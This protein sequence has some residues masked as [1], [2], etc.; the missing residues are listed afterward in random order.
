MLIVYVF[1]F[2]TN[3]LKNIYTEMSTTKYSY[4]MDND[5]EILPNPTMKNIIVSAFISQIN[6]RHDRDLSKY[7]EYGRKLIHVPLPKLVFVEKE[8]LDTYSLLDKKGEYTIH[9]VSL[10][11]VV[12]SPE[13]ACLDVAEIQY[14]VDTT[15]QTVVV[16][17]DKSW[18]YLYKYKDEI[19]DFHLNTSNPTKDTLEYMFVQ[20][21][22][23]E[24]M[25]LAVLLLSLSPEIGGAIRDCLGA[26]GR[27]AH[28][29]IWMDFGLY[30][31]FDRPGAGEEMFYRCFREMDTRVCERYS[32]A[33][34]NGF[35]FRTVYFASC[36][37]PAADYYMDVYRQIHW[38]FAG[39]VFAGFAEPLLE[40]AQKMRAECMAL[41]REKKHLMW[42]I[43]V[44][45][46]IYRK[47]PHLFDFY[48]C[49]HDPSM[50]MFF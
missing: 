14:I 5:N 10:P 28:Q 15:T 31:M 22:K 1:Y 43:N 35:Q 13:E 33:C 26:T 46:L 39:S 30:H 27:D 47:Y 16:L 18:M 11:L 21:Y 2:K 36:W 50:I 40:L 24:W 49:N 12:H 37:P 44:W 25:R 29:F 7:I 32:V 42:E 4:S 23:T 20:C 38:L 6:Q 9:S 19:T 41:I 45:I 3:S 8:V 48:R 34:Q 17:F